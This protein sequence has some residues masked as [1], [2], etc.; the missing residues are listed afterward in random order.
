MLNSYV[1]GY[2]SLEQIE[3]KITAISNAIDVV[4]SGGR[5]Y[6]LNDGQGEMQVTRDTLTNLHT[7]LDYWLEMYNRLSDTSSNIVSI[8]STR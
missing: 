8:R 4:M 6:R 2:F 5:S 3:T 7:A 1:A